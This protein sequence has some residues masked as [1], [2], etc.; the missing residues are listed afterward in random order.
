MLEVVGTALVG[1]SSS[2]RNAIQRKIKRQELEE[3]KRAE[4]ASRSERIRRGVYHDGRLDCVAGNG[5]MSE[6][7]FGDEWMTSDDMEGKH[8]DAGEELGEKTVKDWEVIVKKEELEERER[9]QDVT[10]DPQAVGAL[11]IVV[12][13]NFASKGGANRGELLTVLASWAATLTDNQVGNCFRSCFC[14]LKRGCRL[15]T[16]LLSAITERIPSNSPKVCRHLCHCTLLLITL[17]AL[18]SKPLNSIALYDADAASALSFVKQKLKDAGVDQTFTPEQTA[19]LE[20]L[21]GRAS[22]LESVSCCMLHEICGSSER[23]IFS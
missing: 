13:R 12:I 20:R 6:L 19:Y 17:L 10:E 21:G 3:E 1:V 14:S 2:H 22:D 15:R 4:E 18:P 11:P 23:F 9:K 5:V 8:E 16:S 7:G